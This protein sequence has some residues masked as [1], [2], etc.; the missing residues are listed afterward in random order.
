MKLKILL[1]HLPDEAQTSTKIIDW[2][3]FFL[4]LVKSAC[5]CMGGVHTCMEGFCFLKEG[6][7][8]YIKSFRL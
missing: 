3:F 6:I 7:K 4:T 5:V 1:S 2:V 8:S